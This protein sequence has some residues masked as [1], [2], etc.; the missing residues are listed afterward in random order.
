[1]MENMNMGFISSFG[2]VSL[3]KSVLLECDLESF[4]SNLVG[5]E[6]FGYLNRGQVRIQK[7]PNAS[8]RALR[9]HRNLTKPEVKQSKPILRTTGLNT[10]NGQKHEINF[11]YIFPIIENFYFGKLICTLKN[12]KPNKAY[13]DFGIII[14][15]LFNC[16][17]QYIYKNVIKYN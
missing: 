8:F 6:A 17:I 5:F 16:G 1:M 10:E 3:F 2:P 12:L 14:T 13:S 15:I 9:E 7:Q 11:K 4:G